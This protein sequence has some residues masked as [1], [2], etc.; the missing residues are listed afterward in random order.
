MTPARRAALITGGTRG[1]GR[2]VALALARDGMCVAVLS[3]QRDDDAQRTVAELQACGVDALHLAADVTDEV[4]VRDSFA[5]AAARFGAVDTVIHCAGLRSHTALESMSL[6]HWRDVM[7]TN[8]DAAF[9]CSRAALAHVPAAG[10]RIVFF[11]GAAAAVGA[12]LRAHVAAAKAGVEGL[13]RSLATELAA[14]RITVNCIAPGIIDTSGSEDGT[15][16][17]PAM[18]QLRI[19]AGRQGRPE[20]IAAAVRLL[21]SHEGAYITGQVLHVNGG[22]VYR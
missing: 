9:L 7:A 12:P 6:A 18:Q 15:A 20:E 10:G 5:A 11:S 16:L 19:P 1:I 3:R 14:R 13:T 8:L 17:T 22:M 4:A 2:A 21:V